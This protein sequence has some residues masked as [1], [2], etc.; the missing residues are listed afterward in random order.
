MVKE[1]TDGARD[2]VFEE[3][4]MKKPIEEQF[5]HV[6]ELFMS[7]LSEHESQLDCPACVHS[8]V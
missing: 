1:G 5:V 6:Q 4:R 3:P 8:M 2:T 7:V